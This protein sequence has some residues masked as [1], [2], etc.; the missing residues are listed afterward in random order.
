MQD[1][2]GPSSGGHKL[3]QLIGDWWEEHIVWPLLREVAGRLELFLDSRFQ[4]RPVRGDAPIWQ[5]SEGNSVGYDFVL[6]LNGSQVDRGIPVGFVEGF[7]R[8]GSRHSKDKARD[9]TGK[10]LPIRDT[11]PTARFLG[12]VASGDFTQP[13]REFVAS[14]NVEILCV[15]KDKVVQA[16]AQHGVTIDYLDK[17]A[18]EEKKELA[19]ACERTLTPKVKLDIAATLTQ[20]VGQASFDGYA[21]RVGAALA[22][23]PQEIRITESVHS[24]PAVFN[25]IAAA[26]AFLASPIFEPVEG[27]VSY[28][29]GITYSDGSEFFRE[30]ATIGELRQLHDQL[31]VLAEHMEGLAARARI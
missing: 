15:P 30:I 9:D 29:Y 31:R 18:E 5:D 12:I 7:W 22:A 2:N 4:E 25:S 10:L 20:L 13:A 21:S 17:A 16:F 3:G 8:R 19:S 6:E 24:R 1:E 28:R 27:S 11:Y 26:T 14:R 23:L